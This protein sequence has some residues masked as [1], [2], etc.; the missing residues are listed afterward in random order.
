VASTDPVDNP[1]ENTGED[2]KRFAESYLIV[3]ETT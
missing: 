3:L 1:C 2:D